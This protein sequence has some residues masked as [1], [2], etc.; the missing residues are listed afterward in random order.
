MPIALLYLI[1]GGLCFNAYQNTTAIKAQGRDNVALH[2]QCNQNSQDINQI[3]GYV[4]S[5]PW[6][7]KPVAATNSDWR[8]VIPNGSGGLD[9]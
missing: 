2:Q 1:S 9:R 3:G 4:A 7:A 5:K 6:S 8:S